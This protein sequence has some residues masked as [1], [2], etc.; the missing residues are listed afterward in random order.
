MP[1]VV[2]ALAG[3]DP[4]G[5]QLGLHLG[6]KAVAQGLQFLFG[7]VAVDLGRLRFG[8]AGRRA[9]RGRCSAWPGRGRG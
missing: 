1:R 4:V 9:G 7:L 8:R 3:A 6:G 2:V 5:D